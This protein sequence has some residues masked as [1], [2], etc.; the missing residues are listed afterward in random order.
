M[1]GERAFASALSQLLPYKL[2]RA[3]FAFSARLAPECTGAVAIRGTGPTDLPME[4]GVDRRAPAGC[5]CGPACP[6]EWALR[7]RRLPAEFV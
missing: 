7:L 4:A 2:K 3:Y 6:V 1:D 5:A